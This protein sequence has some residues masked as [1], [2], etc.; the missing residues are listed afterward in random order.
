MKKLVIVFSA[1]LLF[2][3]ILF[4]MPQDSFAKSNLN[5]DEKF[6]D[7]SVPTKQG[8]ESGNNQE[9]LDEQDTELERLTSSMFKQQTVKTIKTAQIGAKSEVSNVK[10][11]LFY[12]SNRFNSE[13]NKIE[14]ILF[15]S[16]YTIQS[17]IASDDFYNDQT[18]RQNGLKIFGFSLVIKV[19]CVG[20][21]FIFK[22]W[23][24]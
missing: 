14:K 3:G 23:F 22:K 12:S 6:V 17:K 16:G 21:Y 4:T 11:Q 24:G 1:F 10:K 9:F 20:M 8:A 19:V 15:T 18:K 5:L 13:F 2:F 7:S